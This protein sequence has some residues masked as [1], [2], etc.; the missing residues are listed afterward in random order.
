MDF[1]QSREEDNVRAGRGLAE[2][3]PPF[4]PLSLGDFAA[5]RKAPRQ[6]VVHHATPRRQQIAVSVFTT[7][8]LFAFASP[9]K[10]TNG[11]VKERGRKTAPRAA[12]GN[13]SAPLTVR[14]ETALG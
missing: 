2:K 1:T 9:L 7:T 11:R 3:S 6:T 10:Q 14:P 5:L 12:K 4:Y 8:G 13:G